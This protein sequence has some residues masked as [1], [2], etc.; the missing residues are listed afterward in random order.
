[1]KI[2]F[3]GFELT[4]EK[5]TIQATKKQSLQLKV[6]ENITKWEHYFRKKCVTV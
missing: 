3:Y 6:L 1:M 5:P 2:Q 4:S